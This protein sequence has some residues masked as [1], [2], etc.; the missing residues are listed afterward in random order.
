MSQITAFWQTILGGHLI[1]L[2]W[3]LTSKWGISTKPASCIIR[4][5]QDRVT[6][7]LLLLSGAPQDQQDL[8]TSCSPNIQPHT[9]LPGGDQQSSVNGSLVSYLPGEED[10]EGALLPVSSLVPSSFCFVCLLHFLLVF[11]N[12]PQHDIGLSKGPGAAITEAHKLGD[13]KQ[14]KWTFKQFWRLEVQN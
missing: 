9:L 14:Q 1:A 13:L 11:L 4:V 5:T 3:F 8:N 6:G 10:A 2:P 12:C 7:L